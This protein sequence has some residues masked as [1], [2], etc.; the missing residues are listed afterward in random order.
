MLEVFIALIVLVFLV[1]FVM[2]SLPQVRQHP[3]RRN[4]TSN[5]EAK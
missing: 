4:Q 5:T 2:M 1:L 3:K